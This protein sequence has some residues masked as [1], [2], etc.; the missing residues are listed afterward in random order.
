[1]IIMD[2]YGKRQPEADAAAA[3]IVTSDWAGPADAD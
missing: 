1:M 3:M 2:F